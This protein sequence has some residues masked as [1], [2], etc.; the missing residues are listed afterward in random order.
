MGE[1]ERKRVRIC[2]FV[3]T[4]ACRGMRVIA[5]NIKAEKIKAGCCDFHSHPLLEYET[6]RFSSTS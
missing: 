4:G 1:G 6:M 5:V 3:Q 2:A